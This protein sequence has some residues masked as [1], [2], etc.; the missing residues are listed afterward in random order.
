MKR[1][2][3]IFGLAIALVLLRSYVATRYE[4]FFFDSDQAIVGLMA[5]HLSR[6]HRFPVFYYSLNYILAVQAWI[7]APFFWIARS[8]VTVMRLPF[9]LLNAAVAVALIAMLSRELSLSPALAFV[10][11]LPFVM[12][13]P[14]T[15]NQMLEVAGANV[16]PFAYVL[17][18]WALRRRPVWFG[19][20]LAI[21]Y[22]HREFTIFAVPA[23]LIAERRVWR[24]VPSASARRGATMLASFAVVYAA[25]GLA[26]ARTGAGG[27]GLQA[28][29]LA[30]QLCLTWRDVVEHARALVTEALP[31]LFGALPAPLNAFRMTTTLVAGS[32]AIWWV[33]FGGLAL[34]LAGAVVPN[35]STKPPQRLD[36]AVYLG[37]T[38]AFTACAYPLSCNVALHTPPLLR[39]LLLA[40]LIPVAIVAACL[41]AQRSPVWRGTVAAA[42]VVWSTTNLVD[43]VRLIRTAAADPP[44][45]EHR[46]LADYLVG[47]GIRYARAIYWDAYMVDFLSRERVIAASTDIIR[48]PEYQEQVDAHAADAIVLQRVP[49]SGDERVASWCLQPQRMGTEGGRRRDGGA[50]VPPPSPLRPH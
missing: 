17:G 24:S 25:I 41:A 4:G 8:S 14:A 9:V 35:R 23:L 10:A 49:C 29:S 1:T 50:S 32:F 12:P 47:H 46:I 43:N 30:G 19:V 22:L 13:T 39:Y 16:E 44:L 18:L 7:V 36:F 6:F 15:A 45:S 40:L 2:T 37:L 20:L 27:I 21:G 42:I 34:A 26:K 3:A 28:A 11:A 48:I 33:V 5:R 38:G 31:T